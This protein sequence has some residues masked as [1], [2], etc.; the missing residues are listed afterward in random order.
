MLGGDLKLVTLLYMLAKSTIAA[1]GDGKGEALKR[2]R[3]RRYTLSVVAVRWVVNKKGLQMKN[4][5]PRPHGMRAIIAL[6]RTLYPLNSV[7]Q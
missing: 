5:K 6:R 7:V 4:I 2:R 1:T 3:K